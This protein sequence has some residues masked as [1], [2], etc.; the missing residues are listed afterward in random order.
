[1]TVDVLDAAALRRRVALT[2]LL[3]LTLYVAAAYVHT[4]LGVSDWWLVP[5]VVL[6]Y[7]LVVRPLMAPVREASRL[8]RALA[9]QAFLEMREQEGRQ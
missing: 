2:A 8:R 5:V 4:A 9:Y 1:M 7:V 3:T 6:L